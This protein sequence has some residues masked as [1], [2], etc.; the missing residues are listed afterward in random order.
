LRVKVEDKI[1][2]TAGFRHPKERLF[3]RKEYS[4]LKGKK[5]SVLILLS[6]IIF[7][8]L[9]S[10]VF[11]KAGLD[12][13]NIKM[14]D[15]FIKW[16]SIPAGSYAFSDDYRDI[17][18]FLETSVDAEILGLE[19]IS[20]SYRAWWRF[21]PSESNGK[22]GALVQGLDYW[23][24][25]QLLQGILAEDNLVK[26]FY[27]DLDSDLFR[28]GIVITES[29]LNEL[30]IELDELESN[31][32]VIK[33]A[34]NLKLKVLA[35]VKSL[36]NKSEAL[37]LNSLI[38][39]VSNFTQLDGVSESK[40]Q[41]NHEIEIEFRLDEGQDIGQLENIITEVFGNNGIEFNPPERVEM[42]H[43][44]IAHNI[45]M[46][47]NLSESAETRHKRNIQN[48][49]SQKY[50]HFNPSIL[51]ETN[52]P[53]PN[54]ELSKRYGQFKYGDDEALMFDLLSF[55]IDLDSISSFQEIALDKF[56]I[57]LDMDQ[58]E[59]KKNYGVISF[60]TIFLILNLVFFAGFAIVV[61]LY[62]LVKSHLNRIRMNIGTFLAFG[63]SKQFLI[64]GYLYIIFRLL[65]TATLIGI[66]ILILTQ[67]LTLILV[68]TTASI[69]YGFLLELSTISNYWM[70]LTICILYLI[71]YFLF[72]K[73]LKRFLS[74]PPGDLIYGR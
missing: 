67:T 17:K 34:D 33:E 54:E 13:L 24:D 69:K 70:W 59:A 20:G 4:T 48:S 37:A 42:T 11:G 39:H 23:K 68:N 63:M 45:R 47:V 64:N 51:F 41:K 3:L 56:E 40:F 18:E 60:L 57:E 52:L 53:Y 30:E 32:V 71:S 9:L 55:R 43:K 14:N 2:Q 10:I 74:L 50:Y 66:S 65:S 19:A 1:A 25:E 27:K 28:N 61:Y 7:L 6:L 21:Y 35:V 31:L 72:R 44:D 49:L 12:H 62:N 36:P 5:N 16:F 15:P 26:K 22:K 46:K 73:Q 8:S 29:F 58:A 38:Y